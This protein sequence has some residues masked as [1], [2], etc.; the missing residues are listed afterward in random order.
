MSADSS[1][2][3]RVQTVPRLWIREDEQEGWLQ[4]GGSLLNWRAVHAAGSRS[5]AS[6]QRIFRLLLK[7]E[8]P[9]ACG[10]AASPSSM[11]PVGVV[12]CLAD[13]N[14]RT[15]PVAGPHPQNFHVLGLNSDSRMVSQSS[16]IGKLFP[17][18][19]IPINDNDSGKRLPREAR[20]CYVT[21]ASVTRLPTD[22][23]DCDI[24]FIS[25]LTGIPGLDSARLAHRHWYARRV[26][27]STLEKGQA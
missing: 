2:P 25:I 20:G 5:L 19:D 13:G 10:R 27:S 6:S 8:I 9:F 22:N 18:C 12:V 23:A 3:G 15:R 14:D 17:G 26:C 7:P 16:F 4:T 1:T 21:R 24:E 11:Y